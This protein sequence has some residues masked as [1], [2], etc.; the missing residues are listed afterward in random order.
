MA[1]NPTPQTPAMAQN[2]TVSPAGAN[3]QAIPTTVSMDLP[4]SIQTLLNQPVAGV[5]Q[6]TIGNMPTGVG[7]TN[8]QVPVLDFRSQ[9]ISMAM[10]GQVPVLDDFRNRQNSYQ[11]GGMV[12]AAGM[13][14]GQAPAPMNPQMA[15][16]QINDMMAKNPEV[17]ARIRAA[18]EAG[19]QSGELS[20][21]EVNMAVQLAQVALQN[22][23]MYPQLRQFAID[24]GLAAPTDLPEQYDEGLV[25][26]FVTAGKAMQADVQ[27]E[28]VQMNP[29]VGN[30]APMQPTAPP[31]PGQ[32]PEM[33][34]GG[35]LKGPSHDQGG[36]PIRMKGGGMIEA[37]G[38]EY[39]IPKAVVAAKGTEFFDKLIGKDKA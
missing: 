20:Q 16:M 15:D 19:I 39:V 33:K 14:M 21:Q 13:Q 34:L 4:P 22:P 17:V 25:I 18:I 31:A 29:E 24:R 2:P 23:Q 5:D 3:R 27:I 26:A 38:G 32:P 36:I 7:R 6:Q 12:P 35:L 11:E 10:G 30:V 8:P 1:M 37:E 28:S 9:P